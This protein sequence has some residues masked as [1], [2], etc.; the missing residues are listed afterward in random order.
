MKNKDRNFVMFLQD[1]IDCA[2]KIDKYTKNITEDNFTNNEQ[3][4]DAVI[5]RIGIVGEAVKNL[6]A[7]LKKRHKEI[8]W[9]KSVKMRNIFMHVYFGID[10]HRLWKTAKEEIPD[11]KEKVFKIFD[12]L[13][14]QGLL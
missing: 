8:N 4:K 6:P 3:V 11:L 9:K 13:K 2:E 1:I 7:G 10:C 5:M 14:V 12:E